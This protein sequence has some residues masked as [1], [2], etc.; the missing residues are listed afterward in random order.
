[1]QFWLIAIHHFPL[2]NSTWQMARF[3]KD[4]RYY[5]IYLQQDLLNDWVIV[6]TN[7]RKKSKLGQCRTIAFSN[8]NDASLQFHDMTCAR[9]KRGYLWTNYKTDSP[10]FMQLIII[11]ATSQTASSSS[12]QASPTKKTQRSPIKPNSSNVP[13]PQQIAFDFNDTGHQSDYILDSF[14]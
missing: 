8:Y 12:R 13:T 1:M 11:L 3:E 14:G 6:A 5:E 7:G 4:T 9:Y 2:T 10:L